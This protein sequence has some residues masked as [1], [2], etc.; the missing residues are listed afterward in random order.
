VKFA[1]GHDRSEEREAQKDR[2]RILT[3]HD[4]LIHQ[5]IIVLKRYNIRTS[6]PL[7]WPTFHPDLARAGRRSCFS[8]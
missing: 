4:N 6:Q 7:Y 8:L 2:A 3:A 1:G 5:I